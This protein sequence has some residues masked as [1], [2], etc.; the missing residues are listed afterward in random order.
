MPE[1]TLLSPE[2]PWH[3][4]YSLAALIT[5]H[6]VLSFSSSCLPYLPVS[7]SHSLTHDVHLIDVVITG[8]GHQ[9][10]QFSAFWAG[11]RIILPTAFGY[12]TRFGIEVMHVT[13]RGKHLIAS[14]Q[15][16]FSFLLT[17]IVWWDEIWVSKWLPKPE[18]PVDQQKMCSLSKKCIFNALNSWDVGV[19]CTHH[20]LAHS[21]R[22][23]RSVLPIQ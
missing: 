7:F 1:V 6:P 21:D 20:N 3:F 2:F 16:H 23:T 9:I 13:F 10:F 4:I 5:F 14:V 8:V 18:P 11:D 12:M 22:C 17:V 15:L 19:V